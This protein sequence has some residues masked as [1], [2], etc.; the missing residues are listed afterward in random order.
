[1]HCIKQ[2]NFFES[3]RK[4]YVCS[5]VA[6]FVTSLSSPTSPGTLSIINTHSNQQG[7]S[8]SS[9]LLPSSTTIPSQTGGDGLPAQDASCDTSKINQSVSL[10]HHLA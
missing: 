2:F 10:C 9:G 6:S 7:C 5:I 1:M 4:Q 8:T 3:S